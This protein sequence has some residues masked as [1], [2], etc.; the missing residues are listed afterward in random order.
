MGSGL[1]LGFYDCMG[2]EAG[3]IYDR[4]SIKVNK[5]IQKADSLGG[6]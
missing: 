6:R 4:V 5:A 1:Y 2:Y 3:R